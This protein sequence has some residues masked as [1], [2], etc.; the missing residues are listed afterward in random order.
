VH[1]AAGTIAVP[2]KEHFE[3]VNV[4]ACDQRI[5]YVYIK[6]RSMPARSTNASEMA[7]RK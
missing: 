1:D 3:G 2:K 7:Q 5:R 4:D 6:L